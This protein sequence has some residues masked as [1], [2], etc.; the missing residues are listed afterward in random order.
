MAPDANK[1][2]TIR[3]PKLSPI[4]QRRLQNFCA[5]R[6]GFWSLWIFLALLL[7]TLPAEF[8]ANDKPFVVY[9]Q[10]GVYVPIFKN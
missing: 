1:R 9:F 2:K 4:T 7:A 5:N 8:V 3:R 10:G 6:R